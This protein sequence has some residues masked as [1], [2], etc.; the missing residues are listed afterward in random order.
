MRLNHMLCI[1]GWTSAALILLATSVMA[2][3]PALVIA[4]STERLDFGPGDIVE[5]APILDQN[6][7]PAV[8]FRMSKEK[9]R[10]FGALTE[11]HIGEKVDLIVCGKIMS[12]PVIQ[13]PILGGTGLV[14]GGLTAGETK[15]LAEL[16]KNG[17]CD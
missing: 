16:M 6:N 17:T 4:F 14:S 1:T 11:S 10:A 7:R 5:A 9:A 13:T 12:S 3:E 2:A 8:G 15:K